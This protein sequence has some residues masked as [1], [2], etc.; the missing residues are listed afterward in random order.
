MIV[1]ESI[2]VENKSVQALIP[3]HQSQLITYLKLTGI[4]L[5]FLV[6]WNVPKIKDGM[7]RTV[8]NL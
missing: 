7:R 5:G 2:I 8:L 3:V 4:Q 6:N 1:N